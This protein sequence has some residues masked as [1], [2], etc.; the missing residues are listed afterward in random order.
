M[1]IPE[2]PERALSKAA[3][4]S[5]IRTMSLSGKAD[6]AFESSL[7]GSLLLYDPGFVMI[8]FENGGSSACTIRASSGAYP[9][10]T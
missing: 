3:S 7:S 6:F 4:A 9:D 8:T 2:E 5:S 10:V 1:S